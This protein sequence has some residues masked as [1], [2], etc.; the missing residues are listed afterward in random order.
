M[1]IIRYGDPALREKS[2]PVNKITGETRQLVRDLLE[3]L[4]AAPGVGLAAIQVG[5]PLRICVIDLRSKD[6]RQPI[7]L[8]NP[9]I[10]A[11][12]GRQ[13]DE[14]GCLSLPGLSCPVKRHE[15]VRVEA[16]NEKG[17][18]VVIEGT[19]LLSR[20]LQH[21]IDHL[22]GKLFLDY[23]SAADKKLLEQE[24]RRKKKQ[25]DW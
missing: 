4:Y 1:K 15:S 9:K 3:T 21:E 11:Q 2:K 10:V 20:V 13:E 22:D 19:G 16:T 23:L 18:P 24:V 8:I 14:E 25:G 17:F 5:V 6:L 12:Q 7:V